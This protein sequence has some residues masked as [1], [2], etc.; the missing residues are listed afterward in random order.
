MRKTT[1]RDILW[2]IRSIIQNLGNKKR[3]CLQWK[4]CDRLGIK[5]SSCVATIPC[6]FGLHE[7]AA[8]TTSSE[9]VQ[10]T[11]HYSSCECGVSISINGHSPPQLVPSYTGKPVHVHM[12]AQELAYLILAQEDDEDN[13]NWTTTAKE[14]ITTLC[15][16]WSNRSSSA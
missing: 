2:R 14:W 9:T 13:N 7:V 11:S 10:R 4:G 3:T 1:L 16:T 12:N 8:S 6:R 15:S 5:S